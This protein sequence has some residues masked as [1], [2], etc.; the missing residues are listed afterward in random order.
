MTLLYGVLATASFLGAGLLL[1]RLWSQYS[2]P[3][4]VVAGTDRAVIPGP[5]SVP[6]RLIGSPDNW[7]RVLSGADLLRHCNA[8][9]SLDEIFRQS[10]LAREVFD[11]DLRSA[12]LAYAEFVQL[13]PASESHHHA[14]PGGLLAHTIEV[15]LAAM[16][17]RNGYLLPLGA[18]T[19]TIDRQRDHWTYA[20]FFAGLLHDIGKIMTDL[21]MQVRDSAKSPDRRWL[22]MSGA[23]TRSHATEYRITFAPTAERDYLA[24]KK[25]SLVLLHGIVSSNALALVGRENLVLEVLTGYLSGE[26]GST[27]AVADGVKTLAQMIKR[28][29]QHSVSTNLKHG[30]R[31]RFGTATTVPLVE[32]LLTAMREMLAQGTA[33]PLNRDGAAG[34]VYDGA[35]WFV[36]KRLADSVRSAIQQ[37]DTDE[38]VPGPTK[39]DRLFDVWQ[40]YA[41]I[42]PNP[43]TGQAIWHVIVAGEG[44]KHRLAVLKFPLQ[45]LYDDPS[46]YP[47]S[48]LGTIAPVEKDETGAEKAKASQPPQPVARSE[49]IA[50]AAPAPMPDSP[51]PPMPAPTPD[52]LALREPR[53]EDL[54]EEPSPADSLSG[55]AAVTAASVP[56]VP[57]P[58]KA[59]Q[60]KG[61][62]IDIPAPRS[63]SSAKKPL[64]PPTMTPAIPSGNAD[65]DDGLLDQGDAVSASRR[66]KKPVNP[67]PTP[68]GIRDGGPPVAPL[69]VAPKLPGEK[70]PTE[71]AIAFMTWIQQGLASGS[72]LYNE[73][74]AQIHFVTQGM[75]LVSP[76]IFREYALATNSDSNAVQQ[77]VIGAG[78]HVKESSSSNI[79]H[80]A[81]NKRDGTRAGKL[82]AVVIH[83]PERWVNPLPPAN[84][85]IVP[86]AVSID[87]AAIPIAGQSRPMR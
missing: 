53:D 60:P 79:L 69:A 83:R 28:A 87:P 18:P 4:D 8:Q 13:A 58:L 35:I 65:A 11:R 5:A 76:R 82:S 63:P 17:L 67:S 6:A 61:S 30:P 9:A 52:R 73:P 24:H 50:R 70:E 25:L 62:R 26:A 75:A 41:V 77:Q 12:V 72:L 20:V 27:P 31:Q 86:F 47:A 56:P 22:P 7:C 36:A 33:L 55:T 21:R 39:N 37:G 16:T 43:T 68:I 19:G 57:D 74:G 40:D 85:C 32:R 80:F 45:K 29:D 64:K 15:I 34:W 66:A 2:T 51:I 81:V 49:P 54:I 84:A 48:M 71:L 1:W 23:L 46:R 14:H 3:V 78:W 10:R 38:G 59:P 42:E 44:Y